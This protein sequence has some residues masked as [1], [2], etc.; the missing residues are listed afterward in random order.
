MTGRRC[1]TLYLPAGAAVFGSRQGYGLTYHCLYEPFLARRYRHARRLRRSLGE[2]LP[3]VGG[4]LPDRPVGM[5]GGTYLRRC[6]DIRAAEG[7]LETMA[8]C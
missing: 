4:P 8:G 7:L 3:E 6:A 2:I 1:R 5:R